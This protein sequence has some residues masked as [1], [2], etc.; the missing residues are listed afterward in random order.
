MFFF[1][2][3]NTENLDKMGPER[4]KA[5]GFEMGQVGYQDSFTYT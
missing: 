3:L 1:S 2:I 5:S 4:K